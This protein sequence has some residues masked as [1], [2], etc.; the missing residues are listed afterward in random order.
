MIPYCQILVVGDAGHGYFQGLGYDAS[1]L[2]G[3]VTPVMSE[4]AVG[5]ELS[6]QKTQYC[7]SLLWK[8]SYF[9]KRARTVI[10]C[11]V[12]PLAKANLRFP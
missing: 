2:F 12:K 7:Q 5:D 4:I 11:P 3:Q 1:E 6:G 8:T 10:I 9:G